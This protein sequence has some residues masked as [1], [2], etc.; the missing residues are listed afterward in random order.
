MFDSVQ[1]TF[2]GRET[3]A[4]SLSLPGKE[5]LFLNQVHGTDIVSIVDER[6]EDFLKNLIT[7]LPEADA[8]LVNT[9]LPG[10][11]KYA[12]AIKTADCIPIFVVSESS[13]FAAA[14]HAGWRG[15][16][17]GILLRTIERMV[18]YGC[19]LSSL[20]VA[21]GPGAGECCYEIS[22]EVADYFFAA[23]DKVNSLQEGE[24]LAIKEDQDGRIFCNIRA[25]LCAQARSAGVKTDN[26]S[27]SSICT[28]CSLDHFSYRREK[29]LAGRQV[30]YFT[31]N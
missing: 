20:K 11:N 18:S 1:A 17:G 23:W 28:I 14:I 9:A 10:L 6:G 22:G 15:A 24:C 19:A 25:L 12:F 26:I 29:A 2:G 27:V 16:V 3:E 30:S 8:W 31:I 4:Q 7:T 13:F 5:L 21:L